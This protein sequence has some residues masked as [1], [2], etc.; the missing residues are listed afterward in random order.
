MRDKGTLIGL[1]G[2]ICMMLALFIH[3]AA[4]KSIETTAPIRIVV[5]D[6]TDADYIAHIYGGILD[7]LGYNVKYVRVE[8]TAQISGLETGD[9]DVTTSIWDTTSYKQMLEA[10]QTGKVNN[11]GSTGVH[12]TENWWYPKYLEAVCPG[13]PDWEALKQEG[14]VKALSTAETAPKGR[15]LDPPPD[16]ET[17]A[18]KRIEAL[19]LDFE[20]ISTGSIITTIATLQ[21]A[22]KRKEPILSFGFIPHWFFNK[23]P[24]EFVKFPKYAPEC[25]D[26]PSYG[27]NKKAT[28]DCGYKIGLVWKL[29]NQDF[30]KRAPKAARLLH[31]FVLDTED[32]SQATDRVENG[33]EKIEAVA[34]DW[35][36]Q[37]RATWKVWTK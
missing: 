2:L 4:A 16:F 22:I 21:A 33:G 36:N 15:F 23:T 26:D 32:V 19:G 28:W 31:L 25:F 7:E 9:L 29:A 35:I 14:C 8:Y 13:L 17:H 20:V 34:G 5:I 10:T 24:G 30:I 18:A 12:V 1:L 11:Y 3:P 27:P 37:N 6:V